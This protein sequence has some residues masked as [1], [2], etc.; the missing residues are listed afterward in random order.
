[1]VLFQGDDDSLRD[2]LW[3]SFWNGSTW[4]AGDASSAP[5]LRLPSGSNHVATERRS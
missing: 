1:V 4:T 2:R 5:M 3:A